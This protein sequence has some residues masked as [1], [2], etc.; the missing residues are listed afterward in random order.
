MLAAIRHLADGNFVCQQDTAHWHVMH[1]TLSNC[2]IFISLELCPQQ[3]R[4]ETHCLQ[5]L[6]SHTAAYDLQI[7]DDLK[8]SSSKCLK[9]GKAANA[10]E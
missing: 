6:G 3:P 4:T 10:F 7:N 5:D 9:S 1:T 2:S 8:K